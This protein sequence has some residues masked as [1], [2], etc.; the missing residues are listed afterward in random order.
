[1][2]KELGYHTL[3]VEYTAPMVSARGQQM[4]WNMSGETVDEFGLTRAERYVATGV[5]AILIFIGLVLGLPK[6]F[7]QLRHPGSV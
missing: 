2:P 1:M 7:R 6:L 4:S 5:P 3:W